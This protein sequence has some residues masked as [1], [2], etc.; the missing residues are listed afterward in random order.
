M[1]D[2]D[3]AKGF[4]TTGWAALIAACGGGSGSDDDLGATPTTAAAE[5]GDSA[6]DTTYEFSVPAE[7]F[8][9]EVF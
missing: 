3:G 8:D 2:Q 4:E 9:C 1:G 6:S 5:S 7:T